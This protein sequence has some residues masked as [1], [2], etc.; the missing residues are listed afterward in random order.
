[1]RFKIGDKVKFLN[2][3][4]GGVVKAIIDS[5]LVKIETDD[6]FEMPVMITE[7]IKDFR[8]EPVEEVR[9]PSFISPTTNP[10]EDDQQDEERV[11]DINPWGM[12]KEEK[13]IYC[14]KGF[15]QAS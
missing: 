13:G 12:A 10:V 2:E 1:M 7:L 15:N 9:I 4:G 3:S 8:A 11:S 5:K 6:G 14:Q